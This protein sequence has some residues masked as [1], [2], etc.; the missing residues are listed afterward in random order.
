MR[1]VVLPTPRQNVDPSLTGQ[2]PTMQ[3]LSLDIPFTRAANAERERARTLTFVK[4]AGPGGGP[5]LG[6]RGAQSPW[7]GPSPSVRGLSATSV[8]LRRT[9]PDRP[10]SASNH[11]E[12]GT[13]RRVWSREENTRVKLRM[14]V[15][16]GALLATAL[17]G[18]PAQAAQGGTTTTPVDPTLAV[19]QAETELVATDP[20]AQETGTK[21]KA[22]E[23]ARLKTTTRLTQVWMAASWSKLSGPALWSGPLTAPASVVPRLPGRRPVA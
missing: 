5:A 20:D 18:S 15:A 1:R 16:L 22:A 12:R 10:P 4:A 6:H 3:D 17:A 11:I 19:D 7:V 8:R 13:I 9:T 23:T 14:T 21:R 2:R